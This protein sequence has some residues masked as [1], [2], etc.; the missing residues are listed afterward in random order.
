MNNLRFIERLDGSRTLVDPSAGLEWA[1]TFA[2]PL[3]HAQAIE[4][5]IAYR[6][7]GHDDWRLPTIKELLGPVDHSRYAPAID[8]DA[9]PDTKSNWYWTSTSCAWDPSCAWFVYFSDG[10]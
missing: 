10:V 1:E 5:C 9:F 3:T 8:T 2:R 6:G 4:A 7:A